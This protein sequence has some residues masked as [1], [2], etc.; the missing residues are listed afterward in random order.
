[1]KIRYSVIAF[2]ATAA[3]AA[4][5]VTIDPDLPAYEP[6]APVNG[7]IVCASNNATDELIRAW[8]AKFAR[9]HPGARLTLRG[10]RK[11]TT[12]AFNTA[13]AAGDVDLVPAAREP[14]ASEIERL[15][16]KTG[17]PPL[18]LAV[19]SGSYA[20]KSGSHALAVYVHRDNPLER[21]TIGELREIYARDGKI[22]AWGDLGLKGEWADQAIRPFSLLLA[23]PDGDPL[24]IVNYLQGRVLGGGPF[25]RGIYQVD[26]TGPGLENHMLTNIVRRVAADRYAIGYSGFAFAQAGTKAL[27]IAESPA[28]PFYR[29]TREEVESRVYPLSRSVYLA[30]SRRAD[31]PVK[32]L[33]RE[34]L[35]F[36][37]SRE[38][39]QVLAEGPEKYLPLPA[40]I[41]RAQL[42][43]AEAAK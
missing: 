12:D 22:N 29:G 41:A 35:R 4:G 26:D 21:I 34:F 27:A 11:L 42:A 17:R 13:I 14:L 23:R 30:V 25:R 6:R 36:V 20:T 1:L 18:I 8:A 43:I 16:G 31:D 39:Q 2:A 15:G 32:P 24:G 9:L 7:E 5:A 40:R 10:E 19:A 33:V 37:L 3:L 28:G 38:G